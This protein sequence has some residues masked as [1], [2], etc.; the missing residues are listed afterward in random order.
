M[1]T[2]H[3]EKFTKKALE[4]TKTES[5]QF[6]LLQNHGVFSEPF[7]A[8]IIGYSKRYEIIDFGEDKK[9]SMVN[10]RLHIVGASLH[11]LNRLNLTENQT[12]LIKFY[13][14]RSKKISKNKY[15]FDTTLDGTW[16]DNYKLIVEFK[17]R[18]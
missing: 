6:R 4:H 5:I 16:D 15:V 14:D 12:K 9:L 7:V 8:N 2:K 18:K 13:K 1:K 10:F 11:K 17:K 3:F